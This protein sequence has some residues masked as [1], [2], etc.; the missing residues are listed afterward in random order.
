MSKEKTLEDLIREAIEDL[1]I[2]IKAKL[3]LRIDRIE[4]EDVEGLE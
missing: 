2:Y 1:E 3:V 4:I